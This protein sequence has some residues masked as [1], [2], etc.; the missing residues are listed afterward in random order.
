MEEIDAQEMAGHQPRFP[1]ELGVFDAHCHPTDT[2]ASIAH[3]SLMR[4]TTLTV[5]ATRGEDQDLVEEIAARF[6]EREKVIPCFGWHPW[7]AHQIA[8]DDMKTTTKADHYRQV[9]TGTSEEDKQFFQTLPDPKPLRV[10]LAETRTRLLAHPHALVGEIGLDKAF[11]LPMPW[12][13]HEVESR[14][15]GL[16]PGSREGR[17]LSPYRVSMDH[18]RAVLKAQLQL[19]GE[20]RRAVSVHSVQAHGAVFE[21]LHSLWQGHERKQESQRERKQRKLEETY[22]DS[23]DNSSRQLRDNPSSSQEDNEPLPYP[24]R[25]CMHSYS[26]PPDQLKQYLRPGVPSQVYFSFSAV[27]NFANPSVE[28]VAAVLKALPDDRILAESDLHC[29]G[30]EIDQ[31]L[32]DVIRTICRLRGWSLE[33]GVKRLAEN[34]RRFVFG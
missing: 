14:D 15:V 11:R 7:F 13:Q 26:G 17:K 3:I 28:K 30:P 33:D 8:Q 18:Q 22:E 32:Q 2:M 25:V 6:A 24:P 23:S 31:L 9:L 19:A 5:M 20:L 34:W 10:L 12:Q 16:T 1:W 29:A 4:A 27:I 21:V